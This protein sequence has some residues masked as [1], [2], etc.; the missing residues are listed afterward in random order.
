M[1]YLSRLF[2]ALSVV[3]AFGLSAPQVQAQVNPTQSSVNEDAMFQALGGDSAVVSGRVTIPDRGA[4]TLISPDNK[5]W[6]ALQGRTLHTLSIWAVIGMIA[7]LT[8]FYL[9]RGKIRIDSGMSGRT[10]LRFNWVERFA[11][12]TLASTFII[13]ALTGLNLIIGKSV[14]LP[15]FGEAAFGTLSAYGK[16]AHNYL[17]WP[18]M[19]SLVMI[20]LLWIVHNIPEK[21]DLDWIKQA[22]GLLKKG[23][24]PPA[25]KFNAGQKL[26]FWAVVIGGAGLSYTGIMMLFPAEAG[27]QA[28]WQFYQVVHALIAAALSAIVIAHI[29]IGSVGME[30]AFDAMGS[31]E[32]D[33]NWAKEHHSLWVE[34]V[35]AT[36]KRNTT[37][38]TTPAE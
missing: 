27:T 8:L 23:V 4:G 21:L 38:V 25:R 1:T 7:I 31:G 19:A 32:V 16:I 36:Q 13:L 26:I 29:Y 37:Q 28:D 11:H 34:E 24:H 18:F 3:L 17:A 6:A 22:G 20:L 33:E 10:I 5:S 14:I 35:K 30:G 15:I 2:V 9:I 12:W